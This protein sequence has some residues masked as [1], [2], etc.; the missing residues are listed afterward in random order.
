MDKAPRKLELVWRGE[1]KLPQS[2]V[3][4]ESTSIARYR[5]LFGPR[6]EQEEEE[7]EEENAVT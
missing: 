6:P 2:H 1:R 3:C 5:I 4:P 7:E